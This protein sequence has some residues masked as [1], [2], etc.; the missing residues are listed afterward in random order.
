MSS[1]FTFISKAIVPYRMT[2]LSLFEIIP[3]LIGAVLIIGMI[4]YTF[5]ASNVRKNYI[6]FGFLWYVFFLFPTLLV[7]LADDFF[8]Y[9]EHRVYLLMVGVLIVIMEIL[10]SLKIDFKKP[11]VLSITFFII[12]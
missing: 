5:K 8:D 4:V 11:L 10:K 3:T 9:A 1:I 6:L 12:R 2:P 7:R